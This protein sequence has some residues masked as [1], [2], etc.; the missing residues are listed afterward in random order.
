V[1]RLVTR[2]L[3]AG[4]QGL[5]F[6]RHTCRRRGA[7][8]EHGEV[9]A[10]PPREFR[11]RKSVNRCWLVRLLAVGAAAGL[12]KREDLSGC[13]CDGTRDVTCAVQH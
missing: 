2:T 13:D 5:L 11:A 12:G 8:H 6:P 10:E 3:P 7:A 1:G 9:A 4:V